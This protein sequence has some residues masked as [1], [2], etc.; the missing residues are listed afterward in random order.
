MKKFLIIVLLVAVTAGILFAGATNTNTT[1]ITKYSDGTATASGVLSHTY[2]S[3]DYIQSIQCQVTSTEEKD[4]YIFCTAR[5]A[6]MNYMMGW[7]YDAKY[8]Q[9]LST[10]NEDSLLYFKTNSSGEII[11]ISVYNRSIDVR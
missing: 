6:E 7:S 11:R 4:I 9:V 8:A 2:Q 3:S 5:D 10:I 1:V